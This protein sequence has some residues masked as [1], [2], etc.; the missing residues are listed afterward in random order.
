MVIRNSEKKR[1]LY[2]VYDVNT[3]AMRIA[4]PI[5]DGRESREGRGVLT[6]ESLDLTRQLTKIDIFFCVQGSYITD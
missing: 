2:F 1:H 3:L 5:C 6:G 4:T